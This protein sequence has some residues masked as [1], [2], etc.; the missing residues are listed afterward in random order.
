MSR[1]QDPTTQRL[2][3]RLKPSSNLLKRIANVT[4]TNPLKQRSQW[5]DRWSLFP[6]SPAYPLEGPNIGWVRGYSVFECAYGQLKDEITPQR[7]RRKWR[8]GSRHS[9]KAASP[10]GPYVMPPHLLIDGSW[11]W[12]TH[13]CT[14]KEVSE[15]S[16]GRS[17]TPVHC[18]LFD[19]VLP[20]SSHTRL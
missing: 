15:V 2:K 16:Q 5:T 7:Q 10:R 4:H 9:L 13:T 6:F 17:W 18:F 20:Q 1:R 14:F 3:R 12:Y 11:A 19:L 8:H